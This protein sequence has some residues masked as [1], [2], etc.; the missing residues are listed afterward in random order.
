MVWVEG[1]LI[2]QPPAMGRTAPSI[3]GCPGPHPTWPWAPPGIW[4]TTASLGSSA[5]ASPPW[6]KDFFLTPN[7]HLPF[8]SLKPFSLALSLSGC[9]KSHCPS[10]RL[11]DAG[12]VWKMVAL[13]NKLWFFFFFFFPITFPNS[14]HIPRDRCVV[15]GCSIPGVL[16]SAAACL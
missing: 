13:W 16:Q 12:L 1:D 5:R 11:S 9:V 4:G 6:M 2:A 8:F 7:L 3:S 10:C 14:S 15:L